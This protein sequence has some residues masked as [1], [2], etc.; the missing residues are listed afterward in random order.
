M[1]NNEASNPSVAITGGG[2]GLGRELALKLADKGYRV[3]GTALNPAE[4]DDLATAS[5]GRVALSVADITDETAV[6]DWVKKVTNQLGARGLDVL[7]SNAGILTPG[8][9]EVLPLAAIKR[10]YE[11]NVFGALAVINAFL[12]SLRTSGGRIVAIGAMTGR[13]PC[14]STGPRVPPKPPWKPS[15]MS[16]APSSSRSACT[17]CW[18]RPAIWSPAGRPKRPPRCDAPLTR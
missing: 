11:V 14:R 17:S 5:G 9:L 7:I 16:I 1:T 13:F 12:P 3:F 8:P 6:T 18:P 10:E 2:S 15:R 4:V